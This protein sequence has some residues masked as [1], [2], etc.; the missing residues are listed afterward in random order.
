ME[1][2]KFNKWFLREGE[3]VGFTKEQ[4]NFLLD[5]LVAAEEGTTEKLKQLLP[6][7]TKISN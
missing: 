4:T 7:L 3:S 6:T 5:M 2:E 1:I